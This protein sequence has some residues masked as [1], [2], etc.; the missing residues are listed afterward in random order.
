MP[1]LAAALWAVVAACAFP[2]SAVAAPASYPDGSRVLLVFLPA[3]EPAPG[4]PPSTLSPQEILL[5]RLDRRPQLSLGLMGATQ[6]RYSAAQTLLDISQGTRTSVAAYKPKDP[7]ELD[8]VKSGDEAYF[9]GFDDA[10]ARA[11]RAP[12]EIY[13]GLLGGSIP[14]GAAYVGVNGRAQQEAIPAANRAGLIHALSIGPARDVAKR[15]LELLSRRRF[16]VA[17]LPTGVVGG[18]ALD[19]LLAKRAP[20]ELILVV[21]TPPDRKAPQLLPT[22]VVGLGPPHALTSDTTRLDGVIAGIDVLPTAFKWL[23]VPIPDHV[24]GQEVRLDGKRDADALSKLGKRLG[25]VNSRRIP[26]LLLMLL[27]WVTVVLALGAIDTRGG[28]RAG[29]RIGALAM[30]CVLPVLLVTAAIAPSRTA[31][32]AILAGG[33]VILA[34]I[35]DLLMGWPRGPLV[36]GAIAVGSYVIDLIRGSPLIIRS[37]LG[38]NPRFGSRYWGIGN[39]LEATLPILMFVAMAAYLGWRAKS[40]RRAGAF[41]GFGLLLGAAIGSGRLGADVGGVMTVGAGAAAATVAMLPGGVTKRAVAIAVL[42]P[43]VALGLLAALDLAT[44]G[45]GHFTRSVL[46][47]NGSGA[48]WD[49]VVRRYELAFGVFKRGLMPFVTVIATLAVVFG[50]RH[51]VRLFASVRDAPAWNA[52]LVAAIA[53]AVAGTLFNDSGPLLLAFGAFLLACVAAYVGGKPESADTRR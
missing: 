13:P 22:G 36:P 46:H 39:E 33:A 2:V 28:V 8:F 4:E 12:A 42:A 51:R 29:M 25:V 41:A 11:D 10:V 45:N 43:A 24:K 7:P 35:T 15:A 6:G 49:T 38:P 17:G 9:A 30:F 52:A 16:V 50:L 40:N 21:Q 1:R 47:A 37:L 26:A 31:E 34:V 53:C 44:G 18:R 32:L 27:V 20:N 48:L 23:G 19:T 14:G 5:N 3:R